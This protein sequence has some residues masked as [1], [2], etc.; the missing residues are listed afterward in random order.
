[1]G[2]GDVEEGGAAAGEVIYDISQ[3]QRGESIPTEEAALEILRDVAYPQGCLAASSV[4]FPEAFTLDPDAGVT[5]EAN[6]SQPGGDAG[7]VRVDL[8]ASGYQRPISLADQAALGLSDGEAYQAEY[9][10]LNAESRRVRLKARG[11]LRGR[12]GLQLA[13]E[14]GA[15]DSI[16]EMLQ[17]P[18]GPKAVREVTSD[19]A[20]ARLT[21]DRNAKGHV[22]APHGGSRGKWTLEVDT[23][24]AKCPEIQGWA[25]TLCP[26]AVGDSVTAEPSATAP[27]TPVP[28]VLPWFNPGTWVNQP[29]FT[30]PQG[31][32]PVQLTQPMP[33]VS[34][35]FPAAE[36]QLAAAAAAEEQAAAEVTA[37]ATTGAWPEVDFV[38]PDFSTK[39]W[40][41][42]ERQKMFTAVPEWLSEYWRLVTNFNTANILVQGSEKWRDAAQSAGKKAVED[43]K[44]HIKAPV[45]EVAQDGEEGAKGA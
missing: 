34:R 25:I 19:V 39:V 42:P 6:F 16:K 15:E 24:G 23:P 37:Q 7:I 33:W 28:V 30:A 4:V 31:A 5:V 44:E 20:L 36:S 32:S 35:L 12:P 1:V 21:Q 3:H 18:K 29:W 2:S 10:A 13:F 45:V 41:S 14:D 43:V 26:R 22:D 11:Q 17:A 38:G 40:L 9:A 27:N 8:I